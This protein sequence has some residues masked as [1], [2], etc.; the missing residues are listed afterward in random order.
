MQCSKRKRQNNRVKN[1]DEALKQ[2]W[3]MSVP[4]ERIV[5]EM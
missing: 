4:E 1:F 3:V 2:R 5:S